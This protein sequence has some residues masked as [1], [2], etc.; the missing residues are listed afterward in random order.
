MFRMIWCS[1]ICL[2][3]ATALACMV[4]KA[5]VDIPLIGYLGFLFCCIPLGFSLVWGSRLCL[6]VQN[7]RALQNHKQY[8]RRQQQMGTGY[9]V[10]G[11]KL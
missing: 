3:F 4:H 10:D 2:G 7:W 5:I 9:W 1:V 8:L 6:A 11:R